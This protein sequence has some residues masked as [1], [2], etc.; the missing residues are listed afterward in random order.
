[1][2]T[3]QHFR[4]GK[5]H[6]KIKIIPLDSCIFGKFSGKKELENDQCAWFS[7]PGKFY[8]GRVCYFLHDA[9]WHQWELE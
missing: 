2:L 1:M 9:V 8:P 3:K 6:A 7:M 4:A 5:I